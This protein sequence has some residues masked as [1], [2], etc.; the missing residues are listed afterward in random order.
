[1]F[2]PSRHILSLSLSLF[3]SPSLFLSFSQVKKRPIIDIIND[4]VASQ[5]RTCCS[6]KTK[7]KRPVNE[8]VCGVRTNNIRSRVNRREKKRI[9]QS[10]PLVAEAEPVRP[11]RCYPWGLTQTHLTH[12]SH[13]PHTL[14][15]GRPR[16]SQFAP[17]W[18]ETPFLLPH[19]IPPRP[20]QFGTKWPL[21]FLSN[22]TN[23]SLPYTIILI[24]KYMDRT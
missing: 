22:A 6:V 9:R 13:T 19:K 16:S 17:R 12:T 14:H 18:I 2:H 23:L 1:M 24:N 4:R 11:L 3:L 15:T 20:C 7:T 5:S 21:R 10:L 8:I